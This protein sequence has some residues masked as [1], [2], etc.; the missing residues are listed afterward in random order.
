[1]ADVQGLSALGWPRSKSESRRPKA[2]R[3]PT[4]EAR[5]RGSLRP[6]SRPSDQAILGFRVSAFLRVS[7][8]DLRISRRQAL[9]LDRKC[10]VAGYPPVITSQAHALPPVYPLYSPCIPLVFPLYI[11][12]DCQASCWPSVPGQCRA[13]FQNLLPGGPAS[14]R[15]QASRYTSASQG[16]RGRSP[17]QFWTLKW[18]RDGGELGHAARLRIVRSRAKWRAW[19]SA[20]YLVRGVGVM[21]PCGLGRWGLPARTS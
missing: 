11:V 13:S 16:S 9:P 2:E 4:S 10:L 17:S 7:G 14:P 21:P 1:M 6:V 18:T 5:T 3:I 8:F 12:G 19:D 20:P 15:A